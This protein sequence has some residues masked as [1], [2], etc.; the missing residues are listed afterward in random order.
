MTHPLRGPLANRKTVHTL[1]ENSIMRLLLIAICLWVLPMMNLGASEYRTLAVVREL[2]EVDVPAQR[3]GLIAEM[4]VRRGERVTLLQKIAE[5]DRTEVSLKLNV[6]HAELRQVQAKADN[7]GPIKSARAGVNRAQTEDRLLG[8]LGDNAVYLEKFRMKNNLEKTSA[9]L[10]SAESQVLQDR[11]QIDVKSNQA[12]LLENDLRL[13][14]VKSPVEGLVHKI[15]KHQGE[16][17]RQGEPIVKV[18]RMD[19]LLVEGF[20]DSIAISPH[21]AVGAKVDVTIQIAGLAPVEFKDLVIEHAAAKLELDGKFPVWVEIENKSI[22]D[23]RGEQRWLIR[24]GMS[25]SM[26]VKVE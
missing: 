23:R 13:A 9:E 26:L 14:S 4:L 20:L 12:R 11:I 16:W 8:E 15:I 21:D 5:L 1:E 19:K 3:D 7:D 18:T 22:E 2:D 25:G 10:N 24:P 6:S 17:V